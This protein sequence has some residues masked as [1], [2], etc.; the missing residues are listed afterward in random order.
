MDTVF[1][2]MYTTGGRKDCRIP[3]Q[4]A[5]AGPPHYALP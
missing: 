4:A 3:E 2:R 5:A 1:D